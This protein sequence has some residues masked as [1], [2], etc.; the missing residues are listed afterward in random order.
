[1]DKEGDAALAEELVVV[2]PCFSIVVHD[3]LPAHPPGNG[4][5]EALVGSTNWTWWIILKRGKKKRR[6]KERK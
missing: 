5:T 1:M 4:P 3:R 2:D 6:R